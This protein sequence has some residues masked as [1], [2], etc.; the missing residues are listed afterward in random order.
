M[1][2]PLKGLG[3]KVERWLFKEEIAQSQSQSQSQD[4]QQMNE[5]ELIKILSELSD[6]IK[7]QNSAFKEQYDLCVAEDHSRPPS[8]EDIGRYYNYHSNYINNINEA[9]RN[10]GLW[11]TDEKTLVSKEEYQANVNEGG[12]TFLRSSCG[13][14]QGKINKTPWNSKNTGWNSN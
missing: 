14:P 12:W 8:G 4:G 10:S 3:E 2:N 5:D 6:K 7:E 13:L 9:K 1:K 11:V